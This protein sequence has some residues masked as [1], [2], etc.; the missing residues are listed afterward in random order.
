MSKTRIIRQEQVC[1]ATGESF[2]PDRDNQV[3]KNRAVQI[4]N[5][6]DRAKEKNKVFKLLNDRFKANERKLARLFIFLIELILL[7]N[8]TTSLIELIQFKKYSA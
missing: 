5:N 7:Y 3:Y 1:P 8:L 4:K 2:I 6:N